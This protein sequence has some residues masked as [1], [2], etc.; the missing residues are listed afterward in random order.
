MGK[1]SQRN[2]ID[3]WECTPCDSPGHSLRRV[4][5]SGLN[6][7]ILQEGGDFF[8]QIHLLFCG[9]VLSWN[10]LADSKL[11]ETKTIYGFWVEIVW[12]DSDPTELETIYGCCIG[13]VLP[14]P[15]HQNR[16]R[17]TVFY[18]KSFFYHRE[19]SLT[20]TSMTFLQTYFFWQCRIHHDLR[21][22]M[23]VTCRYSMRKK[24]TNLL[25]YSARSWLIMKIRNAPIYDSFKRWWPY[26]LTHLVGLTEWPD[27]SRHWQSVFGERDK[28]M[29]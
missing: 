22:M 19:V 24:S 15:N 21:F 13:I 2:W 14:V 17:F 27:C 12:S 25:W 7:I 11:S 29:G 28:M 20:V 8:S 18:F 10:R 3:W 9:R 23:H 16:E 1:R 6:W 5:E 26:E 4:K